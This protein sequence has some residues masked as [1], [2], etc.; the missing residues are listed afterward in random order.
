[1]KTQFKQSLSYCIEK[2]WILPLI[3]AMA[4]ALSF[5]FES[6]W[7]LISGLLLLLASVIIQLIRKRW[8]L[9]CLTGLL[10]FVYILISVLWVI[11]V[12]FAP[13]RER[14]HRQFARKYENRKEIQK[15]TGIEIPGFEV[16]E[17]RML[18]MRPADFEFE[19]V[20]TIKFEK[21]LGEDL[22]RTLD[23][24]CALPVP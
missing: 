12:S 9:G 3:S 18:H 7:L 20:C 1:M 14:V 17:S 13:N 4:V 11:K 8:K 2:W 23:S 5:L 15:I 10:V 16:V 22:F 19:T 21:P 6:E 24:V